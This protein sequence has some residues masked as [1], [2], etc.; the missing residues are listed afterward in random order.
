MMKRTIVLILVVLLLFFAA[1]CGGTP[2]DDSTIPAEPIE[3]NTADKSDPEK[4]ADPGDVPPS[5]SEAVEEAEEPD[6]AETDSVSRLPQ[7]RTIPFEGIDIS[8][9]EVSMTRSGQADIETSYLS[10]ESLVPESAYIVKG[11]VVKVTYSQVSGNALTFYDVQLDEVWADRVHEGDEALIAGDTITIYQSGGYI[12][13]DVFMSYRSEKL[14]IP[15]GTL[16]LQTILGIPLPEEG[17]E[18]VLFLTDTLDP[19][20]DG[21]YMVTGVYQGRYVI[22]E[23]TVSRYYPEKNDPYLDEGQTVDQLKETVAKALAKAKT[24]EQPTL[25][26]CLED[27]LTS[28]Q[29]LIEAVQRD[30]EQYPE[31]REYDLGRIE[32][33]EN[34]IALVPPFIEKVLSRADRIAACATDHPSVLL[35]SHMSPEKA[36]GG[37]SFASTLIERAGAVNAAKKLISFNGLETAVTMEQIAEMDPDIIIIYS[38]VIKDYYTAEDILSNEMLQEVSAVENG[39]VYEADATDPWFDAGENGAYPTGWMGIAWLQT[40]LYPE[41]YTEEQFKEAVREFYTIIDPEFGYMTYEKR[42]GAE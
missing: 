7:D 40:L 24:I 42:F 17:A 5:E 16:V 31:S 23:E 29:F 35:L 34:K 11:T 14:D 1:G 10:A 37:N 28:L 30:M 15:P 4:Q 8:G 3:E 6:I 39:R 27:Y 32:E 18:Y 41:E 38:S 20:Y 26:E 2:S 33:W 12:L 25:E 22:E 36:Y 9:M 21:V 13:S 19:T